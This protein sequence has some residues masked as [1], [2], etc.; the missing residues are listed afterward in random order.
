MQ[1]TRVSEATGAPLTYSVNGVQG[2]NAVL[3]TIDS[4]GLYTAPAIVPVPN[5]V[6]IT[7]VA[8][9]YPNLPP[10]SVTLAV[11]NPIPVLSTVTP[12]SFSE[13]TTTVT[14]RNLST[15]RRSFGTASRFLR[16]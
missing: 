12:S 5:S 13:G 16:L 14:D 8:S 2:G 15:A 4:N 6:T 11:L 3:G 7:S 9:N 1:M 10:G